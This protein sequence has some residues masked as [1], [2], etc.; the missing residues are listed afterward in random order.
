MRRHWLA[1]LTLVL[2]VSACQRH[3]GTEGG[4]RPSSSGAAAAIGSAAAQTAASSQPP[5][6]NSSATLTPAI[7]NLPKL[8]SI[9]KK[10]F[11]EGADEKTVCEAVD[12]KEPNA[13]VR[14]GHIVPAYITGALYVLEAGPAAKDQLKKY[15][16]KDYTHPHYV[17]QASCRD[18]RIL[19]YLRNMFEE[20]EYR[21]KPFGRV[22]LS[23]ELEKRLGIKTLESFHF[24]Y[25]DVL[26][27]YCRAD[28]ELCEELVK[29]NSRNEGTGLC[30][31]ALSLVRISIGDSNYSQ[32]LSKCQQ[33]PASMKACAYF[34]YTKGTRAEYDTGK[35][36]SR[37]IREA[38]AF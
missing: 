16:E 13:W 22:H 15:I 19:L 24:G 27:Q 5:L 4:A 11:P 3:A 31:K 14:F 35:R 32:M 8:K 10:P 37:E 12:S 17:L 21:G 26:A 18:D 2:G 34:D 25:G 20:S 33:L 7:P 36:C 9:I 29:L 38:L 23:G 30:S 28:A 1:L 6:V